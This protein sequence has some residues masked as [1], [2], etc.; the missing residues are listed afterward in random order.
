MRNAALQQVGF[1]AGWIAGEGVA[2]SCL[3]QRGR[4]RG[5]RHTFISYYSSIGLQTWNDVE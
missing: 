2:G 1:W 4:E 5:Y 3:A